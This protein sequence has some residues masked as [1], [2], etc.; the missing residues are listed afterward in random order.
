MKTS[1]LSFIAERTPEGE[2]LLLNPDGSVWVAPSISHVQRLVN[3]QA[4]RAAGPRGISVA[5]IEWRGVSQEELSGK[6]SQ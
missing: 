6:G 1:R 4:K 2:F 5:R 3:I